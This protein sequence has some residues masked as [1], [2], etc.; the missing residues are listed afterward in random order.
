MKRSLKPALVTLFLRSKYTLSTKILRLAPMTGVDSITVLGNKI[1][2]NFERV[3][4][5]KS[6]TKLKTQAKLF[7]KKYGPFIWIRFNCLMV[8]EPIESLLL[9][10][11]SPRIS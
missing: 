6:Q 1:D 2:H 8:A 4:L 9:S 7:L 11:I 10:T 5:E 3:N